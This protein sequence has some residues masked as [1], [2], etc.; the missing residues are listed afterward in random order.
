[1]AKKVWDGEYDINTNWGG[2]ESTNGLPLTGEMVQNVVKTELKNLNEGKVGYIAEKDGTVYFSSSKEKYDEEK[3][4]GSVIS[5]QRYSM[6]LQKDLSNKS[7][8]LSS[9]D[10]KKFIWYF[11]TIE[12][13]TNSIYTESVSVEYHIQNKTEGIDKLI[14][15]TIDCASDDT[16]SGFTKVELNLDEYL[17][18]G[19]SNIEIV[20]KGLRTKQERALQQAIT[21][22]ML[23]IEDITDFSKSFNKSFIAAT[24]V[25]CTKGQDYFYEYRIDEEGEFIFDTTPRVGEGRI[26][27]D[28]YTVDIAELNDGRHVFEYRLYINIGA[29]STYSTAIQR[30]EFIK[31]ET[32]SSDEPQIL[33]FSTYS[34]G[35]KSLTENGELIIN[36]ASQY[37]PYKVKYAVYNSN[38]S[39]TNIEFN[40]VTTSAGTIPVKASVENGSFYYYTIQSMDEGTKK[41]NVICKDLEENIVN[42]EGRTFFI[43]IEASTLNISEYNRALRVNFSSVGKSN[44]STDKESWVSSVPGYSNSATFSETFDWSQGWTENGLVVS[45]G[46]EVTFDYTPFPFQVNNPSSEEAKEYVGGTNGYTLEIEFM[47]QNVTDEN[48][49]LCDMINELNTDNCGLMITG[50]EI[51]FTTPGGESVGSRFKEGD[52]NRA[53]IVIH[54]EGDKNNFKGLVELYMNGV[55]SSIAKYTF[56]DKF[57]VVG[58]DEN[59]NKVS[60]KLKFTGADGADIV[61]KYIRAYNGVMTPDEAVNN[62]IIYRNSATEMLNLYNKNNVVNEQGVITPQSIIELGNIPV[63]V[64]VGRT[65]LGEVASADGNEGDG[66][67]NCD[68]EYRPGDVSVNDKNYY[69]TLED[70]TNKKLPVDMD[71][72]YYNPLDRRKNFK[73]IKSYITPQG[74][75]SMYYPKKN[76]RIYT[77]KNKD[78]RCFF[79]LVDDDGKLTNALEFEDMMRWNFGEDEKD[80]IYEKWRGVNNVKKR[81]YSFKD[82]AQPVKCW[83]LKADFAETS[84]SHNTGIAKLWGDTLKNSTAEVTKDNFVPV[85]KTNAQATIETK[86][87]NNINGDMPDIRTTIDGF[88]IVVFGK[89]SYSD[90]YVFLGKYNFNNDKSTESVFGFCDIDDK[91]PLTDQGRET[92]ADG[93]FGEKEEVTHTLDNM[94]DKYMCCV[95]TL[96]NGNALANFST[97]EKFDESWDDAFEFRYMEIPEEPKEDDYKDDNGNWVENGEEDYKK[98]Y[99]EY[100]EAKH[101]WDNRRYKPFK[102]FAEWVY[103]TRWCDV[104]GNI[105]TKH[106]EPIAEAGT[107]VDESGNTLTT[108]EAIAEY[109]KRKFNKEKWD[110]LDVWKMAAYYIYAMRFGAVDQIVK[111]SMLTS[112]GPFA[113]DKNGNK[114][115]YWDTTNEDSPEYGRYYKWYYINYDNDTIMGVKN[116]GSLAYGPEITRKQKEGEGSTASYIYAGSDSTLWN[117]FDQDAEFQDIVRI[118]DQGISKTMT[119]KTAISMFDEEQVGKW[120]ERIFNKD[121]EY[122]YISPYM[123]GWSYDGEDK[124]E[125]GAFTDQLFKLQGSRTAHRRWWLSRRF[126]LFDGK[127]SSG[128][129]ATKYVEVKCNYGSIGDTFSAIA[130][131]NAYFGYQINNKTFGDGAKDGGSTFEYAANEPISWKLYKNIQIGDPIAIYGATDIL[132]LNLQGLSK[133]L[134][135]VAFVFGNNEDLGNKLERLNLSINENELFSESSYKAYADNEEASGI[136]QLMG[137]YPFEVNGESDFEEGG[138]YITSD[139]EFDASDKNS[140]KFYR[141]K[142]QDEEGKDIFVYYVKLTGGIRNYACTTKGISFDALNKLQSLKMAGYMAFKSLDLSKNSFINDVDVRYTGIS[143]ISFGEGSRIKE[144]KASEALTSLVLNKCDNLKLENITI[145][146]TPLNT[147][148]GKNISVIEVN[149]SAGLNHA[150]KFREFIVA[151]MKKGDV[152]SK[153]L[154]LRGVKWDNV[155]IGELETI[156]EFLIGDENG[157]KAMQCIITGTI[158]MGPDKIMSSDLEMFNSLIAELGGSLTIKIPY[159]NIILNRVKT[160]IVAGESAKYTY[161]LFPNVETVINGGGVVEHYFVKEVSEFDDFDVK[162]GRTNKYYKYINDTNDVR[163]GLKISKGEKDN[164]IIVT[165]EENVIGGDTNTLLMASLTY[166]G[167]TKFDIAPL[168]IKDPTYAVGGSIN[169]LKNIG[170]KNT[171]YVYTLSIISNKDDEPIGTIDIEWEVT[172][173]NVSEYLSGKKISEDKRT[174]TITTSS[175]QPDPTGDLKIIATIKNHEASNDVVPSIPNVVKIEKP[176]LLLNEN[177]VLTIETNPTVFSV[178]KEEGWAKTSDIVM[179]RAEAEAV[180]NIGTA[181]ANVKSENGWSFEEFMYFTNA[182]L[183]M[184]SNGAFA[185]SD[186]TSIVLPQNVTVIGSG[187]FENCS[188]LVNVQLNNKITDIPEKCFLN[189]NKLVNFSLPDSVER[190]EKFAFGGTDIEKIINVSNVFIEGNRAILISNNSKLMFIENDA[191]ETEEWS[192]DTTTNKLSEVFLPKELRLREASY[193]FTLGKYLSDIT[194]DEGHPYIAFNHNMLYANPQMNK[195]VRALPK[196]TESNVMDIALAEYTTNVYDFAFYNCETI[197]KIIFGSSMVEYG[198]GKGAFYG[199]SIEV[200]DL[201]SCVDLVELQESTF[202]NCKMLKE[203]IL[204]EQG[205]LSTLGHNLFVN[206]DS[207]LEISLPNTITTLKERDSFCNT[208]LNCNALEEIVLPDSIV[209]S[210]RYIIKQCANIR[211]VTL[212]KFFTSINAYD[213]IM[214]CKNLEEVVLPLFSYTNNNNEDI[215]V[216]TTLNRRAPYCF[217]ETKCT[218]FAKYTLRLDDN[219]KIM[220][221]ENGILYKIGDYKEGVYISLPKTLYAIPYTFLDFNIAED[222]AV[223][224]SDAFGGCT[225][226]KSISVPKNIVEINEHTFENCENLKELYFYGNVTKIGRFALCHCPY[227]SKIVLMATEAPVLDHG[228]LS[229]T[230]SGDTYYKYHPFGY[231]SFTWVGK[232]T[233]DENTLYLPYGYSGYNAPEWIKPVF[234][235]D[236]CSFEIKYLSVGESCVIKVFNENGEEI[237]D[238]TIYLK[239][240]SGD[241]VFSFNNDVM[242]INY[243]DSENGFVIDFDDKVYH[244]EVVSVY[245][246]R[247][248]TNLLGSFVVEY[249]KLDYVVGSPTMSQSNRRSLFSTTIFGSGNSRETTNEEYVNIT[250]RDYEMLISRVNQLTEQMNKLK[251]KK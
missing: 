216:N 169:G 47:T 95:E 88:P 37:V 20:V 94:L 6:D 65:K 108:V 173:D 212:P 52:M 147:D 40:D 188:K 90:E 137:D 227:L 231:E 210:P 171:D 36:G 97:I 135:S 85:F 155:K 208:F 38:I 51:K 206:C 8:F 49:V 191:F 166:E 228:G 124:E 189:C 140:P 17:T 35:D 22:V 249:G 184:L 209:S 39:T 181:F 139:V 116:D 161:T 179:T 224:D 131:A 138:K 56:D 106:L 153:S 66:K 109:R 247:E 114:G 154:I 32:Y 178:C 127:W 82:N 194:I 33:I 77:Q 100:L 89:K 25:N 91:E 44:E 164:E 238:G 200:V 183:N 177:V 23:D 220:I 223:I 118:A 31:G 217:I 83:C 70:T 50:S 146:G 134:S 99:E 170:D 237:T 120:C 63:L 102:H 74:T 233:K 26:I 27:T 172:G 167:D 121:A 192:I 60:K 186:I 125:A 219:N 250:K 130:G 48:V 119:Y 14:T 225:Q 5:T 248:C 93:V 13:A 187:V 242:S 143:T 129:F 145:D 222:V 236:E 244:N 46:C 151:W 71:V 86:Y 234:T 98:D 201:S 103:S 162:D 198:L 28:N 41:I 204:P 21:I 218:N 148:G 156:R 75:S 59:G 232:E 215:V 67:G 123:A 251:K 203:V 165:T 196:A 160:E 113:R 96:D 211:K 42:G 30:I 18:N 73:F 199:S 111:N 207:L 195:L 69:E 79:S 57:Q 24:K 7:V 202:N 12:I 101:N 235:E 62:Y 16:N 9:D 190:I 126:N 174:L 43:N 11:K 4:M 19:L 87:N 34:S 142:S 213:Y 158:Q 3:Y 152:T 141:Y 185:N 107:E 2:D 214:D 117:N 45:D 10:E 132:D 182:N 180:T 122:K 105:L 115:G 226:I 157:K 84:S 240:E 53:V 175:V 230:T 92:I 144:L 176:L 15:T 149:N 197:K 58:D 239:S 55:M 150:N 229:A 168:L 243:D 110:H 136:E 80:R 163:N 159:A 241:L 128:D 54:P 246:D 1:M 68:E 112:E 29:E 133:N 76:Y 104:D 221:E 193:N 81:K 72:I 205:K 64:F 61:I 245:S 78:T